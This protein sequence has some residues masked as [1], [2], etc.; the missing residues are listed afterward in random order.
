VN[1]RRLG[2][3]QTIFCFRRDS[4]FLFASAKNPNQNEDDR[5]SNQKIDDP[6]LVME[7]SSQEVAVDAGRQH[8]KDKYSK[9]VLSNGER[10]RYGDHQ[11]LAPDG[12]HKYLREDHRC[13][14]QH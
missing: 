13:D 9:P 2:D 4:T 14:H 11:G 5:Q 12:T 10:D 6:T 1:R 3:V 8:G 7:P